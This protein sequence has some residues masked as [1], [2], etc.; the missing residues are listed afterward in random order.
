[1]M[2]VDGLRN[3][4]EARLASLRRQPDTGRPPPK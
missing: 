4:L 3:R 1:M 2:H